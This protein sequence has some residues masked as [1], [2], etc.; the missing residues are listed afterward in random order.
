MA[1]Y[2]V[3]IPR[4]ARRNFSGLELTRKVEALPGDVEIVSGRDRHVMTVKMPA[5]TASAATSRIPFA[6]VQDYYELTLL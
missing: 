3:S 4:E 6:R 5:A 2:I 1:L